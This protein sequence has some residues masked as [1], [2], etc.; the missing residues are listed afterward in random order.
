MTIT[1]YVYRWD[2]IVTDL[3]RRSPEIFNIRHTE[4]GVQTRNTKRKGGNLH[5]IMAFKKLEAGPSEFF[6]NV[7]QRLDEQK[8]NSQDSEEA[9][10]QVPASEVED[11]NSSDSDYPVETSERNH[12]IDVQEEAMQTSLMDAGKQVVEAWRNARAAQ[13]GEKSSNGIKIPTEDLET[14]GVDVGE[15]VAQD[16][17]DDGSDPLDSTLTEATPPMFAAEVDHSSLTDER[18]DPFLTNS[19]VPVIQ[20]SSPPL[21][22][23]STSPTMTRKYGTYRK[24]RS[25]LSPN[26]TRSLSSSSDEDSSQSPSVKRRSRNSANSK[27]KKKTDSDNNNTA[28]LEVEN[29][30]GAGIQRR[31]TFTKEVPA[32]RVERTRPLSTTSN[33]SDQDDMAR[34]NG[35]VGE[36][37]DF[38]DGGPT[39]GG[40]KRSGTFTKEVPAI[41]VERTRPL[42]TTSNSSDQ[43]D[44]N[45]ARNNGSVGEGVDFDDGAPTKSGL[46]RSGTFTKSPGD[47]VSD[48]ILS[49]AGGTSTNGTA[50]L[51]VPADSIASSPGSN[52]RRSGTFTKEKPDVIVIKTRASSTSSASDKEMLSDAEVEMMAGTTSGLKRSGTFT[53]ET[54]NNNYGTN[55]TEEQLDM[56]QMS[57][58]LLDYDLDDTLKDTLELEPAALDDSSSEESVE[59]TLILTD[60][61]PIR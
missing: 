36:G 5:C 3:T 50:D 40:L 56:L 54:S 31:G 20:A 47:Q 34:N 38:D 59:E 48:Q 10:L 27:G 18:S 55:T 60:G 19:D 6:V 61:S 23:D 26:K 45:M 2:D 46:K 42:S 13:S 4:R 53:K 39:E 52:L 35:S 25:S 44:N 33:S 9:E 49:L 14:E 43:D 22:I 57:A 30:A 29:S 21:K 8:D 16:G 32:I 17:A 28:N 37:V 24:K 15:L 58:D 41:R 7:G 11:L 1:T 51:A 12:V